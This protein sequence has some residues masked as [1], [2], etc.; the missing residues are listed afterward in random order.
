M[1][2]RG[3]SSSPGDLDE[4][5]PELLNQ[6]LS[7]V[8][9]ATLVSYSIYTFTSGHG[10]AMMLTIPFVLFGLFRYLYLIYCQDQGAVLRRYSLLTASC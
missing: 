7:S 4:Y 2:R 8:T 1:F 3:C 6:L 5:S 9:A 10:P